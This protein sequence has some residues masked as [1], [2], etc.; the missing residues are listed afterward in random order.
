MTRTL[1][2]TE[3]AAVLYNQAL[4]KL[5][6]PLNMDGLDELR[7]MLEQEQ[8]VMTEALKQRVK[9]FTILVKTSQTAEATKLLEEIRKRSQGVKTVQKMLARLTKPPYLTAKQQP[10]II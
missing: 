3:K 4:E 10:S 6:D 2:I 5:K 8:H 7:T 9:T 1:I